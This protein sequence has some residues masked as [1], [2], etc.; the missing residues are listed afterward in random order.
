[1]PFGKNLFRITGKSPKS[2]LEFWQPP[3]S[4]AASPTTSALD[5]G[6]DSWWGGVQQLAA[7]A[8]LAFAIALTPPISATA[9]FSQWQD[10]VPT[11]ASTF[12]PDEDFWQA[13]NPAIQLVQQNQVSVFNA[14]EVVVPQVVPFQPDEDFWQNAVA[15]VPQTFVALQ[16]SSFDSQ[17]PTLSG[18]QD[19]DFWVNP[20]ALVQPAIFLFPQ[21]SGFDSQEPTLYG[22]FD[23]DFWAN[24]TA[25]VPATLR[26]IYLPDAEEIPAS[27]LTATVDEY[28]WQNQVQ[29]VPATL[30][31]LYLP[32]ADEI[33]ALH[34]QYDEDFWQSPIF[35]QGQTPQA[36]R[37][38]DVIVPQAV[39]FTPDEDFWVNSVSPVQQVFAVPQQV[40]FDTQEPAGNLFGQFDE[41]FWINPVAPVQKT[42]VVPQQASFDSQEPAGNLFGQFDEDFWVNPV[43]PVQSTFL[44]PQ[45][46]SFEQHDVP[47]QVVVGVPDEI[48]WQLGGPQPV[49]ASLYYNLPYLPDVE[50]IPAGS[51]IPPVPPVPPST[52]QPIVLGKVL[53]QFG[54]SCS[55]PAVIL[56]TS[57]D[58]QL[59]LFNGAQYLI[60][61]ADTSLFQRSYWIVA[62]GNVVVPPS[63]TNVGLNL[64]LTMKGF[65]EKWQPA[66]AI[67]DDVMATLSSPN[68]VPVGTTSWQMVA[69]VSA[70]YTG[71]VGPQSDKRG[72]RLLVDWMISIGGN[73]SEG[74]SLSNQNPFSEALLYFSLGMQF[75]GAVSGVD[76]F[77]ANL[78]QYETQQ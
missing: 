23:E 1:M 9:V 74:S 14:D 35:P 7:T 11:A 65:S 42:F 26:Q 60:A 56:T 52:C 61:P 57:N 73:I 45:Q 71:D 64:A 29:P 25:P 39:L 43:A 58:F 13:P 34:G 31:K 8:A 24:P 69:K 30:G 33:P 15:P 12:T 53:R 22:Q 55:N 48:Y 6:G 54:V 19:E 59:F 36:F 44:V 47:S 51:L 76:Q 20:A 41:D 40:S 78:F 66:R 63:G 46:A 72:G 77:K 21:Q 67:I 5:D 37:D 62:I 10:E 38:D 3:I 49:A 2:P 16:Q 18:Q 70:I 68:P 32:D 4:A 17:E 27:T 50:E 75:S 28:F